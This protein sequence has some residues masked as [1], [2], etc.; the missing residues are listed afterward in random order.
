[1]KTLKVSLKKGQSIIQ[2]LRNHDLFNYKYQVA[3]DKEYI[4]I[5]IE[6]IIEVKKQFPKLEIKEKKLKLIYKPKTYKE[7]LLEVL[8]KEDFD[9]LPKSY[10]VVGTIA[11]LEIPEELNKREKQVAKALLDTN[12]NITTVLMKATI[13]GGKFRTQ[14]LKY[15]A[16]K[17]TKET[18]HKENN[19]RLK[20]D[21]EKVYFS[22]RTSHERKRIINLVKKNED[23]LVMFSGCGPLPIVLGKNTQAKSIVGIELNPVGHKYA[24]QNVKLN[25]LKNVEV[26]NGDVRTII[27]KLKKKFDRILMP[28]PKTADEFLVDALKVAKKGT[29]IHLYLFLCNST[30]PPAKANIK[31]IFGKRK[32]KIQ[33]LVKCGSFSPGVFR[34]CIDIKLI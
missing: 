1:M 2:Y 3:K 10:D 32:Y 15:L 24:S 25:K 7:A 19:I 18:I 11:I 34:T 12:E 29:I 14:K 13:H 23:I 33:R 30:L 17:K 20:L 27:P 21:V 16:G 28:L 5:P 22:V 4:Y 6:N 31:K 8:S 9:M 26:I